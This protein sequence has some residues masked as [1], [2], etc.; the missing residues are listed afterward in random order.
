MKIKAKLFSQALI[1]IL[2]SL[3]VIFAG[4]VSEDTSGKEQKSGVA[5]SDYRTVIDSRGVA[6]EIPSDVKRVATVSDGLIE[7]TMY[8][9]GVEGTIVGIGSSALQSEW[10]YSYPTDDGGV[11]NGTGGHHVIKELI[12]NIEDIPLFA[13]YG[14]PLNYET[15]SSLEPDVVIVRLGTSAFWEDAEAAQKTIDRIES[16][17]MPVV[18]LYS[19]NCYDDASLTRISDE[20]EII[21]DV[22]D[23]KEDAAEIAAYL[24]SQIALVEER[25]SDIP[26]DEKPSVLM[27]GLSPTHRAQGGAGVAQGLGTAESYM[28]ETVVNAKN[29][30][31]VDIGT[32]QIVN[33]E[34]VLALDP[35]VIVLC[36]AWGYHP[37]GELTEATYYESLRELKAVKNGRIMSLPW[38]PC[39]CAKRIE[40]PIDV[41][42]IA[43]A[44]YPDRFEDIEL[45]E[46]LIEFYM[47]TYG[48]DQTTAEKL[49]TAQWMDWCVGEQ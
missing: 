37:P 13:Q 29:A 26:E 33:T 12:E 6:V 17:G 8:A 2:I 9:L 14:S 31:Q 4:C 43:K 46:W 48:V 44:A 36:T 20:I 5:G 41:M 32:F 25:T 30:Y 23:K 35:D 47:N 34:Q 27:F 28:I 7:G 24:E 18:V 49:R 19:P 22:F 16:L 38:T 15:L 3:I 42:V 11:V 10:T 21:G 45:D 1:L 40:Y 39:N